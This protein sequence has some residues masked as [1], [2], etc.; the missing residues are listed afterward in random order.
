MQQVRA[1]ARTARADAALSEAQRDEIFR[2]L[3]DLAEAGYM[4]ARTFFESCLAA[5]DAEWRLAAAHDLYHYDLTGER[6][7]LERLRWM[8]A[9][10]PDSYVRIWLSGILGAQ[11]DDTALWPDN[12]LEGVMH[13]AS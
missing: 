2:E 10:D 13:I 3:H 5:L 9:N 7:L 11:Q 1:R 8:L 6:I 4:P 12:A